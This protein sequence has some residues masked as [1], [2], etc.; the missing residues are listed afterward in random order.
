MAYL[1]PYKRHQGTDA[2]TPAPSPNPP[3]LSL[4]SSFRG[5]S[6]S[7]P[8]GRPRGA[9]ARHPGRNNKIFHAAGCFSRWSPLPPF[10]PSPDDGDDEVLRLEPFPCGPIERKTGAKPLAL[11]SSS[12]GQD[13]SDAAEAAAAAIAERFLPDL[14]VAAERVMAGEAP[15]EQQVRRSG[16]SQAQP[17]DQGGEGAVPVPTVS[18]LLSAPAA[19]HFSR[20]CIMEVPRSSDEC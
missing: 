6:V 20:M 10:S 8:R 16:G 17:R 15:K 2:S 19:Y 5:L 13:S 9:G 11:V 12:P 7:S 18:P 4:S 3:P 14:L 1:P